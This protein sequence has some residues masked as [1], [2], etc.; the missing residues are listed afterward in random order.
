MIGTESVPISALLGEQSLFL[1]PLI[2]F[3]AVAMIPR[4]LM[5][6]IMART[7]DVAGP[8]GSVTIIQRAQFHHIVHE[9]HERLALLILFAKTEYG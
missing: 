5:H 2:K 9:I 1:H 3:Q 7:G 6:Q 4:V 8:I